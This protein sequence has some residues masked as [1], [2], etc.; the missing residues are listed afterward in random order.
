MT[1]EVTIERL[2]HLGDGIAA[3]PVFVPRTLPGEVVAGAREGDRIP[4]P[5]IRTPSA[6][7]VAAACPHYNSCGACA[8]MH[9]TDAFVADWKIGI[10]R[11]A[12]AGYGL[13]A[14]IAG[15]ATSPP[16]SRRRAV[17]SGR[18]TKK[19]A[20]VGFHARASDTITAIPSCRVVVPAIRAALAPLEALV[21]AG[22]SRK[23]EL[24]ITV[25]DGPAGLDVAVAGGK[26]P[27]RALSEELAAI[28]GAADFAR[29]SWNDELVA[30]ARAPFQM[31]DGLRV[32]PPPGAFLQAT[33]A[34]EAALREAVAG[35]AAGAERVVDLYAGCG[36]FALPLSRMAEIHAVEG[37]EAL[38]SATFEGWRAEGGL[39][40]LSVETRDLS[41][42]PLVP[43]ELDK[44]DAA[45]IDPPRAGA[46][47]QMRALVDSAV[48][49]IAAVSC[50]PAT[51]ARD[52]A[53]AVAAGFAIREIRVV[54]QFRWSPHIELVAHLAR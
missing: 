42:R 43:L 6:E 19:G 44:F 31:M 47:A 13:D 1:D 14:P 2:G 3:G 7:R 33:L 23:G 32:V 50:N 22:G 35:I 11:H 12:L 40:R 28:A 54:D 53:I 46:E 25:T 24:A 49:T 37:L 21:V 41:S 20:L 26:T 39:H 45:V 4:A 38:S 18:R 9:A 15:I 48:A 27:D 51:F 29:L 8:V 52:A 17:L 34:G 16:E 10:V 30:Q 36:T 5:K